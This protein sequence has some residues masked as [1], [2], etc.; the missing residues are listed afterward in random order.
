VAKRLPTRREELLRAVGE[1][2]E[3]GESF[4]EWSFA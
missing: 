4:A 3:S 1:N 2:L